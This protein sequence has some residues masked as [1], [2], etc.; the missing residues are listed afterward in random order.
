M[1]VNR[2]R[3]DFFGPRLADHILVELLFDI[4]W[5]GDV[6]EQRLGAAAPAFLLVDDR[7]AQ[8]DA[9]ATDVNVARSF[10]QRP[11]VA[12]TLAAKRAISVALAAIFSK[13]FT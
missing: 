2:D 8:L 13:L 11:D 7:L 5:R 9:F 12:V 10:D 6:I 4:A 3:Q 1:I